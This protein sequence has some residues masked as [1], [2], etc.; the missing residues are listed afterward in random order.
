MTIA[1]LLLVLI[2]AGVADQDREKLLMNDGDHRFKAFQEAC[3]ADFESMVEGPV[4]IVSHTVSDHEPPNTFVSTYQYKVAMSDGGQ[5]GPYKFEC[6]QV[7]GGRILIYS[8]I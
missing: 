3:R 2:I 5:R 6:R 4:I 7:E 8:E 1:P